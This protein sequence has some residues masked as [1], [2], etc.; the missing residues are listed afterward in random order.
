LI[1]NTGNSGGINGC[2]ADF[3]AAE[4]LK[5]FGRKDTKAQR[6]KISFKLLLI[7]EEPIAENLP[8]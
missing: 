8:L 3:L 2:H 1:I 5:K 6:R 4:S 7:G